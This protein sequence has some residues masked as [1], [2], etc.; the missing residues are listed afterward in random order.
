MP[1][2][3]SAVTDLSLALKCKIGSCPAWVKPNFASAVLTSV[4]DTDV[5]HDGDVDLL[6][7]FRISET[8]IACGH[9]EAM[10]TGETFGGELFEGSDSIQTVG[11]K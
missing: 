3:D 9:T 6:L 2:V 5:D 1:P 10:L 7:R 4:R 8:G 11:C